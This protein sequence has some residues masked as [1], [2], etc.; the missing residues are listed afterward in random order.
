MVTASLPSERRR[1][2]F[3][4][5]VMAMS[6]EILER[7]PDQPIPERHIR[8]VAERAVVAYLAKKVRLEQSAYLSHMNDQVEQWLRKREQN[9]T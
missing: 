6:S 1:S 2:A 7:I 8:G 3:G 5:Q 9:R 4:R